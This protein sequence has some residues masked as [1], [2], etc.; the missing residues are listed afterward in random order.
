MTRSATDTSREN[1][2]VAAS[3]MIPDLQIP[4]GKRIPDE[5]HAVS[6]SIPTMADVIGYEERDPDTIARMTLAT[7]D[8]LRTSA[9][10]KSN[11]I[12]KNSSIDP[13]IQSGLPL[14][15]ESLNNLKPICDALSPN[16]SSIKAYPESAYPKMRI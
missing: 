6:V 11:P 4:L 2:K 1:S 12:G 7:L 3:S 13:I 10:S 16:S 5:L 8:S 14:P 9:S 15:N